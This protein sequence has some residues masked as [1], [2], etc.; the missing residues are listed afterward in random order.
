MIK[1]QLLA[2]RTSR[3]LILSKHDGKKAFASEHALS[4]PILIV[5]RP[6][7]H[8][9]NNPSSTLGVECEAAI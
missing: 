4:H 7:I 1:G 6:S 2:S 5:D 8:I 9:A 3:V